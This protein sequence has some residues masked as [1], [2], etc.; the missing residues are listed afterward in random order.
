M[1]ASGAATAMQLRATAQRDR[2]NL[3]PAKYTIQE[4]RSGQLCSRVL[5]DEASG[6]YQLYQDTEDQ[7]GLGRLGDS[8]IYL[9]LSS[10]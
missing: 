3:S 5:R 6:S 9:V 2:T 10:C 4:M 8:R 1:P 7:R